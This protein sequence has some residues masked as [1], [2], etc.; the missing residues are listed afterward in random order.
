M[1]RP[2]PV[3]TDNF[4]L[5]IFRALRHRRVPIALRI[6]SHNV[7]LVALALVIYACVMGLQ[8][9]QA[10]HQQADDPATCTWQQ[11]PDQRATGQCAP[12]GE[13]EPVDGHCAPSQNSRYRVS[14]TASAAGLQADVNVKLTP[15]PLRFNRNSD[16]IFDDP[17]RSFSGEPQQLFKGQL[18]AEGKAQFDIEIGATNQPSSLLAAQFT[19]RV[20]EPGGAFS[21]ASSSLP[22]HAYPAY[23]G[24]K[25][26]KGDAERDMLLTDSRHLLELAS[27]SPAGEPLALPSLAV[28]R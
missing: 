4:F 18:D 19:S 6:A 16:F 24:L 9:K 8:F 14:I 22:F 17:S 25:L 11:R 1:N 23:V 21:L 13:V 5:L 3:K 12:G 15:A 27:L 26:P 10:M 28:M 2:T 7:I 20:F